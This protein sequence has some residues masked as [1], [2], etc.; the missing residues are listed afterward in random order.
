MDLSWAL[1]FKLVY[2][3]G[4]VCCREF[5]VGSDV[6]SEIS[7]KLCM[8]LMQIYTFSVSW[9]W[10]ILKVM[11][12]YETV[13]NSSFRFWIWVEWMFVVVFV[14]LT[15]HLIPSRRVLSHPPSHLLQV[16]PV[17]T[18]QHTCGLTFAWLGYCGLCQRHRPTEL[19]HSFLFRSCVYFIFMASPWILPATLRSLTLFFQSYFCLIGPFNYPSVY[20]ILPQPWFN[21][22]WLTGCKAPAN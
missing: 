11:G 21:P 2:T 13:S 7:L 6:C 10:P 14:L 12:E 18:Q 15:N 5:D 9:P 8:L 3:K 22:L 17:H 4:S 1:W 20:E 19:A 16:E